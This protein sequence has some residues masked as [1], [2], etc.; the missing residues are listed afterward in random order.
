MILSKKSNLPFLP[1]SPPSYT[2]AEKEAVAGCIDR[3]WTGTG[4][5]TK[6]FEEEFS[7]YKKVPHAA[8]LSSCTSALFLSLKTLGIGEGDEVITTALTFC[9]TIN[10]IL[11]CGAKPVLCDIEENT[12]N[13]DC[14]KIEALINSKTKAIIPV[15]YAGYPCNMDKL[16][17]IAKDY[18]LY[19]VEDCAH[20]IESKFKGQHCG[21][22]GDLG[23]FSF[24]ATKN[25]AIGEGGMAISNSESLINKISTL[26]LHG[27]SRDAWKRFSSGSKKQYDVIENGYK[28]NLTDLQSSIGLIQLRR[29]N[30][31]REIRKKLWATYSESLKNTNLELPEL[32]GDKS[33]IHALHLYTCGLPKNINRDEFIWRASKDYGVTIG[34]HYKSIPTYT[35]FKYQ[36]KIDEPEKKL[37]ISYSWGE[38]TISL[39]LSAGVSDL[40]CERIILCI[41]ELLEK[42]S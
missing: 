21:T 20:A 16:N 42:L 26:G 34:V 12:K 39:S 23:C 8:A 28:M 15:H 29:I 36:L 9:S 17:E 2:D 31:M 14:K 3:S 27:L 11:H 37:P 25:I 7:L 24:Y 19:I 40:D 35:V 5:K 30:E 6:K 13:I 22:F 10:I 4:L 32:P 33:S 1:F 41:K 38:K 18:E